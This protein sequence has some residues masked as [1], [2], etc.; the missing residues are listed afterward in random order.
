MNSH[1]QFLYAITKKQF[2]LLLL[3]LNNRLKICLKVLSIKRNDGFASITLQTKFLEH[4][5][6]T[7]DI[8]DLGQKFVNKSCEDTIEV[9][10]LFIADH[11]ALSCLLLIVLCYFPR[12]KQ[13]LILKWLH[14][15][16][17]VNMSFSSFSLMPLIVSSSFLLSKLFI[18]FLFFYSL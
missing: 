14:S 10:V 11:I 9:I 3:L 17:L 5:I 7:L 2:L 12:R 8:L 4:N 15:G 13:S 18:F 16:S 1:E 6:Y